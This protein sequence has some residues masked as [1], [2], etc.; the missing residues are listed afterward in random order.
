MKTWNVF[1]HDC[2][3]G[4]VVADNKEAAF[5]AARLKWDIDEDAHLSVIPR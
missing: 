3:A 4:T 2:F 1:I 5:A